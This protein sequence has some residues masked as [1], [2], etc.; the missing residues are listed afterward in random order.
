MP[1]ACCCSSVRS[2]VESVTIRTTTG[3]YPPVRAGLGS[4]YSTAGPAGPRE[5]RFSAMR[6]LEAL[7]D[8]N[9]IGIEGLL[10]R[11]Q[12]DRGFRELL[13][14]GGDQCFP[15]TFRCI[16]AGVDGYGSYLRHLDSGEDRL[17]HAGGGLTG[18]HD[19]VVEQPDDVVLR[20]LQAVDLAGPDG[21]CNLD[22]LDLA[23]CMRH[24]AG[25]GLQVGAE[26][27]GEQGGDALRQAP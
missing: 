3:V 10:A 2:A 8:R 20:D 11:L 14:H 5:R 21:A 17:H 25:V 9:D 24:G 27:E 23:Q 26:I 6:A 13:C 7:L 1:A 12:L 16:G 22:G 18:F 19:L 15:L 4:R